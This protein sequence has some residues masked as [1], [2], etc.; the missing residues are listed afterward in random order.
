MVAGLVLDGHVD[1][2]AVISLDLILRSPALPSEPSLD[3]GLGGGYAVSYH[4]DLTSRACP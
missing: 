3:F 2:D 1:A 4:L